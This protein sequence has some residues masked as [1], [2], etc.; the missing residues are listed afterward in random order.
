MP[1]KQHRLVHPTLPEQPRLYHRPA[2]AMVQPEAAAGAA[3]LVGGER[4]QAV[5]V[6]HN[7]MREAQGEQLL[8]LSRDVTGVSKLADPKHPGPTRS[9]P[10]VQLESVV[11]QR[12]YTFY[13]HLFTSRKQVTFG[14]QGAFEDQLEILT[15]KRGRRD[16]HSAQVYRLPRVA[17]RQYLSPPADP[18][19]V[20]D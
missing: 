3:K 14:A 2:T 11:R 19:A 13:N 1:Q 4:D 7:A 9:E 5:V 6:G 10:R 8:D 20:S 18:G 12:K 17:D 16:G 15:G